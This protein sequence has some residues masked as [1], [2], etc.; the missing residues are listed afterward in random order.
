MYDFF[1][2]AIFSINLTLTYLSLY[3]TMELADGKQ[4]REGEREAVFSYGS[5][6]GG[7][8]CALEGGR[9]SNGLGALLLNVVVFDC[10]TI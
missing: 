4:E 5:S 10:C 7:D 3:W 1:F 6:V 9:G 2:K 8:L